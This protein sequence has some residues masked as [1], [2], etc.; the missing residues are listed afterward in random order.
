MLPYRRCLRTLPRLAK[1][2]C[3]YLHNLLQSKSFAKVSSE[4]LRPSVD[5]RSCPTKSAGKRQPQPH[6]FELP[7]IPS[8]RPQNK[9]DRQARKVMPVP[10][11]YIRRSELHFS[12]RTRVAQ[13]FKILAWIRISLDTIPTV[14]VDC[15]HDFDVPRSVSLF[16]DSY[17]SEVRRRGR[18]AITIRSSG[19]LDLH[20]H[21]FLFPTS[22]SFHRVYA[23]GFP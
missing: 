11:Q 15:T 3:R 14:G 4:R 9:S 22:L 21:M 17:S 12:K 20:P 1:T 13:R 7:S 5:W 6:V 8:C 19:Y 2:L 23:S 10:V 18:P 16:Q